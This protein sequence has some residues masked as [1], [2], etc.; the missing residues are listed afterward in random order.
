MSNT[1]YDETL[2]R[3]AEAIRERCIDEA[4]KGF[5]QGG[6]SGL[7]VEGR[8]DLAIDRLRSL[9]LESIVHDTLA[10]NPPNPYRSS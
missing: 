8:L 3:I 2:R 7:C 1:D 4:R 6:M 5:E 10:A 9:D